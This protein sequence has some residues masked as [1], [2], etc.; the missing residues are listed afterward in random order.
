MHFAPSQREAVDVAR[1]GMD[2]CVVAGPGSGKATVLVEYFERLVRAGVD[3][4]RILA[5]TFTEKAAGNMRSKLAEA[6]RNDGMLRARL[7]RAW[8][9]TVHGFCARL[10]RENAIFAGIDPEF[11]VTGEQEAMRLQQVAV[12]DALDGV[13][14]ERPDEMR[15]LMR[16]LASPEISRSLLAAYEAMRAAGTPLARLRAAAPPDGP[17]M[18]QVAALVRRIRLTGTAGWS[19][20]QREHLAGFLEC[21]ERIAS[22]D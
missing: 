16:G 6:F 5:I 7:E 10:L 13:Y 11:H 19:E 1:R 14:A 9:S 15:R 12:A 18:A 17:A 8:V 22:G 3:P 20:K 21:C 2:T 4:L